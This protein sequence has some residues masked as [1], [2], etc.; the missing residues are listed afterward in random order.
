MGVTLR[1]KVKGR[2]E[3]WWVFIA[4]NS[5]RKSIKVGSK[6]AAYDLK[7]SIEPD[8]VRGKLNIEEE[9][10]KKTPI[11]K[12]Y[13]EKW[14]NGYVKVALEA[15]GKRPSAALP[16]SL[17]TEAYF[18]IRLIPRDFGS[19]AYGHFPSASRKLFFRQSP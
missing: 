8:L 2:G 17:V 18:H 12:E 7:R 19:L 6:D 14:V 3:P 15:V 1:Q 9:D 13:S 5:K 11:F 4:H 16:S 10:S